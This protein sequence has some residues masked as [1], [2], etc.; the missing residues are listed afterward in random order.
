MAKETKA[1]TAKQKAAVK[2]PV[3]KSSELETLAKELKTLIPK[4]DEEGLA[5]L[6]KQ[7]HVH[8]YNMQVD[9]LNQT[10]VKDAQRANAQRTSAAKTKTTVKAG[11]GGFGDIRISET[12]SGYHILCNNQW[13]SFTTG[14]ITAMVKIALGEGS[15]LEVRGRL[16]NWLSRERRDLL[17]AASIADKFDDKL[18]TLVSLLKKNFKLKK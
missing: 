1:K 5:F 13:V 2:K 11:S 10:I 18:K 8:L 9:A 16:Y 12:G 14:E 17:I 6:V 4:L 15:D 3:K 7:A